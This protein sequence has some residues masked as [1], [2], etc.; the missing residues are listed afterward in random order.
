M[1]SAFRGFSFGFLLLA[2]ASATPAAETY[3]ESDVVGKYLDATQHQQSAMRGASMEVDFDASVPKLQKQGKLKALRKISKVGKITY[4]M[5]GFEGD[6]SIKKEVIARYM[7]EEANP[8]S[9]PD[10]GINPNNYKFKFKGLRSEAGR[11]VYVLSLSPKRKAVGLFKGE[12]WLDRQTFMP[13]REAG[14][15]VKSPSIFLKKMEF[16]RVYQVR[17]G[18]AIP[19][20][21]QSVAETRLFGPVEM[22]IQFTHF[23]KDPDAEVATLDDTNESDH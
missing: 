1:G 11:P 9:G 20:S 2:L 21:I 7:S 13:V 4:R 16:V 23:S 18:V 17:N 5:L 3:D 6:T 15:F 19:E 22:N 8:Q 10:L 14:R 12:V